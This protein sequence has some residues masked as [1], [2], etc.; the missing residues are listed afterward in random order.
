MNLWI[1]NNISYLQYNAAS[2]F[3]WGG[4]GKVRLMYWVK[5]TGVQNSS[6][7]VCVPTHFRKYQ[8]NTRKHLPP[9]N[10]KMSKIVPTATFLMFSSKYS[11]KIISRFPSH[12]WLIK[13]PNFLGTEDKCKL[14]HIHC[15]PGKVWVLSD[16][17]QT[18]LN[19]KGM[20]P[21]KCA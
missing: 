12:A 19:N 15:T 18:Y 10:S 13:L 14:T 9:L 3:F 16:N 8:Q 2:L 6:K 20:I 1:D 17:D 11:N 5:R 7:Q 4:W 21:Q